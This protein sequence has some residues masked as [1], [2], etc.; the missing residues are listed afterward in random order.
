MFCTNQ[1]VIMFHRGLAVF[2]VAFG[3]TM[4]AVGCRSTQA[5][6][7][8]K[9]VEVGA[10]TLTMTDTAGTNQHT[11]D[12]AANAVIT[13]EGKACGLDEVKAGDIVTVTTD[14]K[15]GKTRATKIEAKKVG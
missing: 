7:Q 12:V 10:G 6:H 3:L 11:H 2:L 8:G 14:T 13:C 5:T 4:G 15:D 1:E 9:V